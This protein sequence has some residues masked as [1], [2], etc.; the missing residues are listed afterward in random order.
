V[1]RELDNGYELD[2]DRERVDV[3][4]LHRFL[5]EEAY[6]ALGRPRPEVRRLVDEATRVVSA[7]APDGAQV[8][9]A[10]VVSDDAV[11]AYL[12][13]VFVL[14]GHRGRGLGRELVREAVERGPQS[15]LRWLLGTADAH[16]FY[17]A[18]G[19]VRPSEL[20]LERPPA[21]A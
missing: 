16:D 4:L 19:F 5:S 9:F 17:A 13:D 14:A 20:M 12:A 18:F 8:G 7:F 2:D 3:A 6:W 10:R 15:G 21:E 1:R 11:F